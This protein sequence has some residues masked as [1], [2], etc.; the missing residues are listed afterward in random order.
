MR[1]GKF[2]VVVIGLGGEKSVAI[3]GITYREACL[4]MTCVKTG[5]GPYKAVGIEKL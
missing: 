3:S 2:S 1:R 5:N 4:Y